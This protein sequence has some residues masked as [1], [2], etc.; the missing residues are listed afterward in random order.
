MTGTPPVAYAGA[1]NEH[2][3]PQ[4]SEATDRRQDD[5]PAEAPPPRPGYRYVTTPEAATLFGCGREAIRRRFRRG[6]LAGFEVHRPQGSVILVEVPDRGEAGQGP[7]TEVA[8]AAEAS[9]Q[10]LLGSP[11][12]SRALGRLSTTL[13]QHLAVIERQQGELDRLRERAARA[14][15]ERDLLR[16]QLDARP[17]SWSMRLRTWFAAHLDGPRDRPAPLG[18]AAAEDLV[19]PQDRPQVPEIVDGTIAAAGDAPV[20]DRRV[21]HDVEAA[22]Q[23]GAPETERLIEH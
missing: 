23:A 10:A 1:M 6:E 21:R 18:A 8:D 7:P 4:A 9:D 15:S 16:A 22:T 20:G 12:L 13:G 3:S 5:L 2:G 14:E 17:A 19:L 11:Q